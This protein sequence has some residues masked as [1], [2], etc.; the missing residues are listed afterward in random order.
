MSKKTDALGYQR[1]WQERS[2]EMADIQPS[3][4]KY[5]REKVTRYVIDLYPCNADMKAHL[6][7]IKAR[8]EKVQ[9]Y[10]KNLIRAD[11]ELGK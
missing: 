9:T 6:E 4:T 8:G 11:M 7:A 2:G 3:K 10:I 1:D 5:F